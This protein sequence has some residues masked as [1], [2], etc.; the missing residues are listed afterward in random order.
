MAACALLVVQQQLRSTIATLTFRSSAC[1]SQVC[2]PL[3]RINELALQLLHHRPQLAQLR[4]LL[5]QP[6]LQS[7]ACLES[8]GTAA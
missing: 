2:L 3:V 5:P 6:H 8:P 7:L 4:I 1:H